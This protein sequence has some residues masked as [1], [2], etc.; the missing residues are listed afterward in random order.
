[1]EWTQK[2][3]QQTDGKIEGQTM[4]QYN[5]TLF[6]QAYKNIAKS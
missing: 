4:S 3:N 1:M 2:V 5:I 6:R